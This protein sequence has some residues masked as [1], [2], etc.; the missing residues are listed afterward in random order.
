M[1]KDGEG[2]E[3][4]GTRYEVRGTGYG[5]RGAGYEVRGMGYELR[6]TRVLLWRDYQSRRQLDGTS[7]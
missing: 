3:V 5:V 7:R 4:R 2:N 6:G 1:G